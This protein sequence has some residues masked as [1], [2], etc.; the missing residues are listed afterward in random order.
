MFAELCRMGSVNIK[1]NFTGVIEQLGIL[2]PLGIRFPVK[3]QMLV[4]P[5]EDMNIQSFLHRVIGKIAVFRLGKFFRRLRAA[6]DGTVMA[7]H[8]FADAA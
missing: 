1:A 4:R 6:I 3:V 7:L 8:P 2:H 5:G